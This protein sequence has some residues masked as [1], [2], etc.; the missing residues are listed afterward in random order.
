MRVNLYTRRFRPML[1]ARILI[2]A[3]LTVALVSGIAP[4]GL[5]SSE[6]LCTMSCC[7]GKAP[8]KAGT[9]THG[10]CEVDFSAQQPQK[11]SVEKEEHCGAGKSLTTQHGD[12]HGHDAPS[13][14]KDKSA[15][16][17]HQHHQTGSLAQ[18]QLPK[19]SSQQATSVIAS[20]LTK[21]CPPNCG[22]G[23]CS[24]SSQSRPRDSAALS[25]A[26]RPR[27]P[28]SLSLRQTSYNPAKGL[29][30]LCRR[31]RPRGPPIS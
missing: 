12:M 4:L 25:D 9:C 10:T 20:M 21:P 23:I 22:A 18:E 30:V 1:V 14:S 16:A 11:P 27:P 29:D 24:Y 2:A 28:S 15:R 7:A 3:T 19:S 5:S 17:G 13:P 31:S 26:G 8:H 6:A